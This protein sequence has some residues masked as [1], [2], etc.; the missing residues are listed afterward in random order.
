MRHDDQT[1]RYRSDGNL[2]RSGQVPELGLRSSKGESGVRP[3]RQNL[4]GR[5]PHRTGQTQDIPLGR[6]VS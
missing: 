4:V 1:E 3:E 2:F 5:L 6:R